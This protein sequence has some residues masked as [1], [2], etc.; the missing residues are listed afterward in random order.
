[1]E[2]VDVDTTETLTPRFKYQ[3]LQV[4]H[5][6][7]NS[8]S[9]RKTVS[10]AG[11]KTRDRIAHRGRGL[12]EATQRK[13]AEVSASRKGLGARLLTITTTTIAGAGGFVVCAASG[14]S[15]GSEPTVLF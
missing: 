13:Q 5:C 3:F 10:V 6:F 9:Y 8:D 14:Q 12:R 2:I 15:P 1:M 11:K 4:I 7:S